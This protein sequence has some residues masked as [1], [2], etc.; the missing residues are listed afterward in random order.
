MRITETKVKFKYTKTKMGHFKKKSYV[1]K[2]GFVLKSF[3]KHCTSNNQLA[4]KE[5]N[6]LKRLKW[7]GN[8]HFQ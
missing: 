1:S 6:S 2:T 8:E 4:T 5:K 7:S 3:D